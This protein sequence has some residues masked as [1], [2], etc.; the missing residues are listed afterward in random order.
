VWYVNG[1]L[2]VNLTEPNNYKRLQHV[3]DGTIKYKTVEPQD[4]P[5]GVNNP[6]ATNVAFNFSLINNY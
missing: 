5:I 2:G 3:G 4:V 1:V 6:P